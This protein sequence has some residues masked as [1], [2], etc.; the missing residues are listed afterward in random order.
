VSGVLRVSITSS[1]V[2]DAVTSGMYTRNGETGRDG[3]R[4]LVRR[5]STLLRRTSENMDRFA[6]RSDLRPVRA[7]LRWERGPVLDCWPFSTKRRQR[8]QCARYI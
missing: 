4:K 5:Q 8:D 3:N 7:V 1:S 6:S 2:R